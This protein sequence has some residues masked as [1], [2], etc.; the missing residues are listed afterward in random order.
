M[1]YYAARYPS[2]YAILL[3]EVLGDS[4]YE[5]EVASR[6]V[7]P[8][9][10]MQDVADQMTRLEGTSIAECMLSTALRALEEGTTE[11]EERLLHPLAYTL[12]K[13]IEKCQQ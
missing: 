2:G 6:H 12:R 1:R 8:H 10:L 4:G 3:R 9:R 5:F 13:E 11:T 7:L